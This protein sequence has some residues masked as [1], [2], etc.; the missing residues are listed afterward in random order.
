MHANRF[1]RARTENLYNFNKDKKRDVKN[2]EL[3]AIGVTQMNCFLKK[4]Q[5][6]FAEKANKI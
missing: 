2:I 3:K 4:N 1:A 5:T 6:C